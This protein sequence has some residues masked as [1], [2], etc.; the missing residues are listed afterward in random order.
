MTI[1]IEQ[2]P[3]SKLSNQKFVQHLELDWED[4]RKPRQRLTTRE[5]TE[6]ILALPRGTVLCDGDLLYESAELNITVQ[7]KAEKVLLIKPKDPVQTCRVAHHLGNWHRSLQI[8]DDGL[9]LAQFDEPMEEWLK[10]EE[11]AYEKT[12]SC[13]HPNCQGADH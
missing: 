7:A 8:H 10:R 9:L 13:F 2:K 6:I 1:I 5:G 12:S 4:R 11:I 3:E